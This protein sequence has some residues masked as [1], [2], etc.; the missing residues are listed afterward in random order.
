MKIEYK[1]WFA[2]KLP[3]SLILDVGSSPSR[4]ND[5]QQYR[6]MEP[7]DVRYHG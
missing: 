4:N 3:Q 1:S 2:E 5:F 7:D 6:L